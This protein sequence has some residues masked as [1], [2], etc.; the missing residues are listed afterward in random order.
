MNHFPPK[1]LDHIVLPVA[2]L[3][4]ARTRLSAL[5][6]TVAADGMHP[7]GTSN[8]CVFFSNGTYLE[9]LAVT[10]MDTYQ[11]EAERGNGFLQRDRLYRKNVGENGFSLIALTSNDAAAEREN[12]LAQ[13]YDCGPIVSFRRDVVQPDGSEHQ[14][15]I[16]LF[17][18]STKAS[19]EL[20]L[21]SCQWLSE[22]SFDEA[23]KVHAN[24]AVGISSIAIADD[25]AG[26]CRNYLENVL[27]NI[28]T[29]TDAIDLEN[30]QIKLMSASELEQ[31]YDIEPNDGRWGL[32]AVAIDIIVSDIFYTAVVLRISGIESKQIGKRL[33]VA[34]A[35]GQGYS[36]AFTEQDKKSK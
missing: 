11:R 23:L 15:S 18:T 20:A 33:V 16:N 31:A 26:D 8:S 5:G 17:I 25:G 13:G 36:I 29:E 12:Y 28:S 2:N 4:V 21:F 3:D 27:G 14:I 32:K 35:D 6:F 30:A 22:K 1:S 34:P 9:P 7:F 24:G 10:D 19:P